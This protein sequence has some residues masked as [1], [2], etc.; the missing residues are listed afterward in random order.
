MSA[1]LPVGLRLE[2]QSGVVFT[3]KM[4]IADPDNVE[5][6]RI[7]SCFVDAMLV[8]GIKRVD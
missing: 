2:L 3:K 5:L 8:C 4:L 6:K 1:K 7:L